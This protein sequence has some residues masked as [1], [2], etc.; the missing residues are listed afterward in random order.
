MSTACFSYFSP[1]SS[2]TIWGASE[3]AP[4]VKN[5]VSMAKLQFVMAGLVPAISIRRPQSPL[6]RSP[7][8]EGVYARLRACEEIGPHDRRREPCPG[9]EPGP[10]K[11]GGCNG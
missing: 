6:S 2:S 10:S 3:H 8:Q 9:L 7:G 5:K 4:G 11:H 1:P